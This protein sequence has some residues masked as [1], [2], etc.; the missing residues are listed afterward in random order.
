MG[1]LSGEMIEDSFSGNREDSREG[2]W[3]QW[4]HGQK[5]W[6][7]QREAVLVCSKGKELPDREEKSRQLNG[8][9]N[10]LL[11]AEMRSPSALQVP[12]SIQPMQNYATWVCWDCKIHRQFQGLNA[13]NLL[14][15]RAWI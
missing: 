12:Y 10:V 4:K 5:V 2:G 6:E 9:N 7:Y 11:T 14:A 15:V 13:E 3:P 8:L 1:S